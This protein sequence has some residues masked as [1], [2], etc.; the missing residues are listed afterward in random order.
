MKLSFNPDLWKYPIGEYKPPSIIDQGHITDWIDQI[1]R[2]P[3]RLYEITSNMSTDQY[4]WCYRPD[5]WSIRELIH[6][7]G[8]SHMHALLR[9][10][11][12]LFTEK[13]TILGY[14][15]AIWVTA[16][17]VKQC[18]PVIS[19]QLLD[20]LHERWVSLLRSLNETDWSKGYFH[21]ETKSFVRI[22]EYIGSYAWHCEHHYRHI[23]LAL[24]HEGKYKATH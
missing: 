5:G 13:P 23:L 11:W 14:D 8:D 9:L 12:A 19:I 17:D 20:A 18:A 21:P 15:E 3:D 24:D 22:D 1:Q 6:H 16:T 4:E 10:K 2:F 7:C